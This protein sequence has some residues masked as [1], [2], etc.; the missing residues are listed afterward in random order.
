M[1]PSKISARIEQT[2]TRAWYARA[3][4]LVIFW[5]I[6]LLVRLVVYR[7]R[8]AFL[9]N[10]P[11]EGHTPVVVVGGIT[12][13]GTGKTPVIIALVKALQLRG[14]RVGVVSRGYGGSTGHQVIRVTPHADPRVVGDEPLLIAT[15]TGC[16]TVVCTQRVAALALLESDGLD[17]ILSDDG[18][19]HYAMARDYEIVVLD[20]HRG[21]GNGQLI[22]M[23]PLREPIERL[24]SVDWVLYRG[25]EDPAS[26]VTYEL[27]G[28]RHLLSD[29]FINV[30]EAQSKW[31]KYAPHQLALVAAIGQP[32]QFFQTLTEQGF[33]GETVAYADH[34]IISA[35]ELDLIQA[36]VIITTEKDAVKMIANADER[37]WVLEI[38][39]QLPPELIN[40]VFARFTQEVA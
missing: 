27:L 15:K 37:I 20:A 16:P 32:E 36:D 35:G 2:I 14:L 38:S 22:P 28:F 7:R 29:A 11:R 31:L 5:P 21:V 17:L 9:K 1:I 3:R 40:T 30:A 10:T 12:V 34:D 19:Q 25:G 18:L 23:G 6:A 24:A 33:V 13:G 8:R 4:W 39:A 26:A